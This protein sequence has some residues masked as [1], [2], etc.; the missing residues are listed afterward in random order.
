MKL[1]VGGDA[2]K[3]LHEGGGGRQVCTRRDDGPTPYRVES[4]LSVELEQ[5]DPIP[6]RQGQGTGLSPTPPHPELEWRKGRA[7]AAATSHG[8]EAHQALPRL[9]NI[10]GHRPELP[11]GLVLGDQGALQ[12]AGDAGQPAD[13]GCANELPN[14]SQRFAEAQ[15]GARKSARTGTVTA[16]AGPRSTG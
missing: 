13:E 3:R 4:I 6:S 8:A 11:V 15:A 2:V 14:L 16:W 5:D 9:C 10:N 12:E 1:E 7:G